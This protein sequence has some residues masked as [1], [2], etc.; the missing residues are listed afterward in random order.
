[1]IRIPVKAALWGIVVLLLAWIV[2]L[3]WLW[4]PARQ[5]ELHTLNLLDRASKQDLAAVGEMMAPDYRDAWGHGKE[6]ALSDAE[7]F[8]RHFFSLRMGPSEEPEIKTRT[9]E[10]TAQARLG[11]YGSGTPLAHAI[12]EAVHKLE[13]PFVFRWRKHGAW[14]WQWT[15]AGLEQEELAEKYPR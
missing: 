10:A 4:S 8:G 11:V 7:E 5:V 9:G 15:L 1:M 2:W 6:Q 14:P 3:F 12:I 13:K